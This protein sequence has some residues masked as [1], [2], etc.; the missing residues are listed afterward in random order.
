MM[1]ILICMAYINLYVPQWIILLAF[2]VYTFIKWNRVLDSS[3]LYTT[4]NKSN[5]IRW[6]VSN[7]KTV[8]PLMYLILR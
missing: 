5:L 8:W 7:C 1:F 4:M 3:D 2:K 6:A